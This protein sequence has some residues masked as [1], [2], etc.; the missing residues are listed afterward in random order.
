MTPTYSKIEIIF[1]RDHGTENYGWYARSTD[2]DGQQ[3]DTRIAESWGEDA[4]AS[5]SDIRE[6]AMQYFCDQDGL[7]D[8]QLA[9]LR[10]MIE[11]HA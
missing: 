2:A 9:D 1:D 4:A 10:D 6:W 3:E 8:A 5:E 11:V 7:T